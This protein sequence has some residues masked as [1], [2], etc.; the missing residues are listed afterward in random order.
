[1]DKSSWIVYHCKAEFVGDNTMHSV[2]LINTEDLD[3]VGFCAT[4]TPNK[5]EIRNMLELSLSKYPV[6]KTIYVTKEWIR[7]L[8]PYFPKIYFKHISS[9]PKDEKLNIDCFFT[10][11]M[12]GILRTDFPNVPIRT[13]YE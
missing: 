3:I 10:E 7:E 13:N 2:Y 9:F 5:L 11:Y 12:R 1:M 6:P 8:K 4:D